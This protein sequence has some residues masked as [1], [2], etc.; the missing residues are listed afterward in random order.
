M[1]GLL[2]ELT[3]QSFDP[4]SS[5]GLGG[6]AAPQSYEVTSSLSTYQ[7]PGDSYLKHRC[8]A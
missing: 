7:N 5:E 2:L 8:Q 1:I 3:G 4:S 6:R